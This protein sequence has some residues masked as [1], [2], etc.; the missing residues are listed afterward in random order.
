[1]LETVMTIIGVAR[2]PV[3]QIVDAVITPKIQSGTIASSIAVKARPKNARDW[4]AAPRR[5]S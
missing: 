3:I 4:M 1:L 5:A 2:N